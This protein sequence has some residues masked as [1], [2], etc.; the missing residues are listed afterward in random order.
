M[1]AGYASRDQLATPC[2]L[3]RWLHVAYRHTR[4]TAPATRYHSVGADQRK[5]RYKREREMGPEPPLD[6]TP[7]LDASSRGD[8]EMAQVLGVSARTIDN[9]WALARAWPARELGR[10]GG[11]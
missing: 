9:D 5:S 2:R 4:G 7:V 3:N 10:E 6:V 11:P 1:D 8:K